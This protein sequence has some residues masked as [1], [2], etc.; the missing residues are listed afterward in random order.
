MAMHAYQADCAELDII[1]RA[2]LLGIVGEDG[3]PVEWAII[4]WEV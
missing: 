2:V 1:S 3:C 4:L